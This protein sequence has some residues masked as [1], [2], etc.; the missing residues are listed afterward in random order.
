MSSC[1]AKRSKPLRGKLGKERI[2]VAKVPVGAAGLTPASR[3][4]SVKLKPAGAV[5]LDQLARRLEQ[6]LLQIAVVIG[7]RPVPALIV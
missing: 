5:L 3:A 1:A 4:A 6:D 7:A 2:A